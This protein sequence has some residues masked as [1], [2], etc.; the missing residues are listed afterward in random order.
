MRNRGVEEFLRASPGYSGRGRADR[1][2]GAWSGRFKVSVGSELVSVL[3]AVQNP[4]GVRTR[5][6]PVQRKV[7]NLK[8]C[9][10]CRGG[11]MSPMA[12]GW[13]TNAGHSQSTTPFLP[14]TR[15]G[16]WR[17]GCSSE[18]QVKR[19]GDSSCSD[20]GVGLMN[21]RFAV[22]VCASVTPR[23]LAVLGLIAGVGPPTACNTHSAAAGA[24]PFVA[25]LVTA[26]R[27]ISRDVP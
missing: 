26:T 11:E 17:A 9:H 7:L 19:K 25:P 24:L 22:S 1:G 4:D 23:L 14:R 6:L 20:T 27:A 3:L 15:S 8:R 18:M 10:R 13:T 12:K 16:C 5:Q 21:D 2:I